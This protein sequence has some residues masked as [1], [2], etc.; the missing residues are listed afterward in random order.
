MDF[1]KT[2]WENFEGFTKKETAVTK[3][4][5]E[6]QVMIGHTYERYFKSTMSSNMIQNCRITASARL[7]ISTNYVHKYKYVQNSQNIS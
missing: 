4:Y 6:A 2:V 7:S 5:R 3:L 1:V